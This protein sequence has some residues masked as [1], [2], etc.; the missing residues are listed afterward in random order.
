MHL[1][2]Q[3][4]LLHTAEAKGVPVLYFLFHDLLPIYLLCVLPRA[5]PLKCWQMTADLQGSQAS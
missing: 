2:T 4:R 5:T 3:A 1:M